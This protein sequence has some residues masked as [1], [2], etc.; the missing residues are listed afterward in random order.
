MKINE[1]EVSC[2]YDAATSTFTL[3]E[4][5]EIPKRLRYIHMSFHVDTLFLK[6][7]Q[8]IHFEIET[9]NITGDASTR[10]DW[11]DDGQRNNNGRNYLGWGHRNPTV[12]H[13]K[14]PHF[15]AISW[16]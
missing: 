14:A 4:F 11:I 2:T 15:E 16:R 5:D 12:T 10:T 8:K 3:K 1:T 7:I 9:F 6:A 13:I